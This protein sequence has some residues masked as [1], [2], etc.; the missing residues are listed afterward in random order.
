M[1]NND[2]PFSVDYARVLGFISKY[3]FQ[4]NIPGDLAQNPRIF[5]SEKVL[6]EKNWSVVP[7]WGVDLRQLIDS[8]GL[9][10]DL[11]KRILDFCEEKGVESIYYAMIEEAEK[12]W[13]IDFPTFSIAGKRIELTEGLDDFFGIR[14]QGKDRNG[15]YMGN[16]FLWSNDESF[17]IFLDGDNLAF[18]VGDLLQIE[19]LL[20]V[21]FD[22]CMEQY[23]LFNSNQ[24]T[25]PELYLWLADFCKR[26]FRQKLE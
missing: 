2:L 23:L 12:I 10:I 24:Q 21:Q 9:R 18:I 20:R 14:G 7:L 11:I 25:I 3:T 15:P 26:N 13:Y 5:F 22:Y 17:A 19:N 6:K 4:Y 16:S 1:L 8:D